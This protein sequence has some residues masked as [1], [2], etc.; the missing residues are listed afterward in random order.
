MSD[1]VMSVAT[2][3]EKKFYTL[4][5]QGE[6]LENF[7]DP[8]R[9]FRAIFYGPSGSGKSTFTLKFAEYLGNNHGKVLYNSFE[10]GY[11]KTL[12]DRIIKTGVSS[13]RLF[14]ADRMQFAEMCDKMKKGRYQ[15]G[16]IDSLQY[17]NFTYAQYKRFVDLFPTKSLI[18]ISQVNGRGT[19]KGGTDIQH[20]VD[21]K[22]N[23]IGGKANIQSRFATQQRSIRLFQPEQKAQQSLF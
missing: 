20:A 21:I 3:R 15:F 22:V 6:W 18:V 13:P 23:I 4:G 16:I 12:Q 17:M 1:K 9:N 5:F 8:E 19:I 7:G 14:F 10:E 2:L 11:S